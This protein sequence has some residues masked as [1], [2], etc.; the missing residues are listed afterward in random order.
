MASRHS[1]TAA[2]RALHRGALQDDRPP[3]ALKDDRPPEPLKDDRPPEPL[4][5]DRP[6]GAL[7]DHRLRGA[8]KDHR[9]RGALKDH[10]LRGALKDHRLRGALKDDPRRGRDAALAFAVVAAMGLLAHAVHAGTAS[11]PGADPAVA[12]WLYGS[13]FGLAALSCAL[14]ARRERREGGDPRPWL[15]AVAGVVL[16]GSAEVSY[17]LL[18]PDPAAPY[19]PLTRGLLLL[20]FAAA[21]TTLALLARKRIEGF[22]KGLALDGLIG[23]LAAAAVTAGMLFPVGGGPASQPGPPAVFLLA[24]LAILAFVVV[25]IGLTGWRPGACW[26]LI[27]AGIVV[28]SVGNVALVHA[29]GAGSF[30][31]GTLVD[32]LYLLSALLLGLAAWFPIEPTVTRHSDDA[33]RVA[34]PLLSAVIALGILV[35]ASFEQIS[36]VAVVLAA[37]TM[38]AVVV[39]TALAFRDNVTLLAARER[40][41]LTDNLTGLGNRRALMRDLETAL[42]DAAA[43]EPRS[44]ILFDLDGFKHYN[45]SFGHPAGDALL[46]R[47]G[48]SFRGA[49]GPHGSAYRMGG[50]EFCAIVRTDTLKEES[51][52]AG[53]CAALSES[54]SGFT[55]R[56]SHGSAALGLE[57]ADAGSALQLADQRM[58]RAKHGREGTFKETRAILLSILQER[59]PGLDEHLHEI[60]RLARGVAT[61]LGLGNEQTDIVVRAAELHDIGKMA[62]PDAIL[63][64]CGPLSEQE[65]GVM[66]RHTVIG[67]RILNSVPALRPVAQVVRSTHERMDGAGYPDGLAGEAIPLAA[68]VI[69]VCDAYNAITTGRAYD[70]VRSHSEAMAELRRCAGTQFDPRVVDSLAGARGEGGRAEGA[71]GEGGRAEGA[72]GEGSRAEGARA[73]GARAD[74]PAGSARAPVREEHS[75]TTP[76]LT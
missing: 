7:K 37:A 24:D 52:L 23:G 65:W 46:S 19:P 26:A 22:Q 1:S 4:K 50:D 9:L 17:R 2:P 72:R 33:R 13:L 57:A 12:D 8:L 39:R 76:P 56:P 58:Y 59:E 6:P 32:S 28:N 34:A 75:A 55:V 62:I 74:R 70:S 10:R 29:T 30:E 3:G 25:S 69:A 49:V 41:S 48:A 54:G 61:E 27:S 53:A 71:R 5:D 68:R 21:A 66:R 11:D 60:A 45:D 16:W 18:E 15:I 42:R 31:R 40:D 64:K 14:R 20:S 47:L 38:V 35:V 36:P 67:E 63:H 43:G 73:E 44:L 51:I